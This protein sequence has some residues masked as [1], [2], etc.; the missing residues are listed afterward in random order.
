MEL[1]YLMFI[2]VF[3]EHRMTVNYD[4]T[5]GTIGS[6]WQFQGLLLRT[7]DSHFTYLDF[8]HYTSVVKALVKFL[9]TLMG[10]LPVF[11]PST[12]I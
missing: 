11:I 5:R 4:R 10:G 6:F 1:S 3:F 7:I 8:K 12:C 9:K 2:L